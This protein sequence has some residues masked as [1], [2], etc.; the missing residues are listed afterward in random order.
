[1]EFSRLLDAA[2]CADDGR[3][4]VHGEF[5]GQAKNFEAVLLPWKNF[6]SPDF[7]GEREEI[8]GGWPANEVDCEQRFGAVA[9]SDVFAEEKPKDFKANIPPEVMDAREFTREN[10]NYAKMGRQIAEVYIGFHER[11]REKWSDDTSVIS[12]PEILEIFSVMWRNT[13]FFLESNE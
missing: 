6:G 1:M 9:V 7:G 8:A 5:L 10:R 12:D 13:S 4:V 3:D 11:M 2:I